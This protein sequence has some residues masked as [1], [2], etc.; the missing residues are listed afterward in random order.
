LNLAIADECFLIGIPFLLITMH[1]GE[2]IFGKYLCIFYILST[3]VT[4][5]TS[6]IFLFI[7]SLDR[8]I[9]ICHPI[10]APRLRTPFI[11]KVLVAISWAISAL[12][13]CPV[14]LAANTIAQKDGRTSCIIE[15]PEYGNM[16]DYS[17]TLYSLILG[18]AIPLLLIL[19]FYYKVSRY[20]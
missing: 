16:P 17:F 6:S 18:F 19:I 15:W 3:S 20:T 13:M 2:W 7:M 9:A 8:Y 14:V 12:F 4:Q 1:L 11:S 5:F 10:S